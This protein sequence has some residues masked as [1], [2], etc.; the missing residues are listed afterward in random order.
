MLEPV[1]LEMLL[2]DLR[3]LVGA[4]RVWAAANIVAEYLMH[5]PALSLL[6]E[7]LHRAIELSQAHQE[8]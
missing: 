6:R 3:G 2:S 8:Y 5:L 1:P 4:A 7:R